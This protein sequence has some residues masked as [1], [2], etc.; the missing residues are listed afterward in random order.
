MADEPDPN[1]DL[2][3]TSR[4]HWS[5][6]TIRG[7]ADLLRARRVAGPV[8]FV[9]SDFFP[10]KYWTQLQAMAPDI[11]WRVEDDLVREARLIKS[12][13]ELEAIRFGGATASRALVKLMDGLR[14]GKKEA[15][16][17][18]D[19]AAEVV[20]GGGHV[21]MMF[22]PAAL[23][24]VSFACAQLG[25]PYL[26]GGDG[27]AEGGWDCSGV[28]K[29]A[30]AAAGIRLPRVA[31]DQHNAGPLV[32]PGSPLRPGPRRRRCSWSSRRS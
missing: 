27:P 18:A 9:G 5:K 7:V 31:Q 6:N 32:P 1:P 21:H 30:Y 11:D 2:I 28:T 22:A 4:I 8:G 25:Q 17:A 3:A 24:A 14:A 20:R 23:V 16:A 12:P 13:R 15:E 10:M 26:W 29:A 19:A